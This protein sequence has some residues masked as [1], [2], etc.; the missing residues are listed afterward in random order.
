MVPAQQP[1]FT[2]GNRSFRYGDG[3]FETARLHNKTLLLA[4]YHFDR[5]F[6]GLQLLHMAFPFTAEQIN[7]LIVD[8]CN[9]ND[10]AASARVRMAAYRDAENSAS[11]LIEATM[12]EPD[13]MQWHKEGWHVTIH[14]DVRKA[15]DVLS[16]LKSANYLPYVMAALHAVQAGVDECLVLN[17]QGRVCDGSKT[18][19]F[20]MR[21]GVIVTPAL[22]EGPVAGVMRRALIRFLQEA[23]HPFVE[24]AV[25]IDDLLRADAVFLTNAIEGVRWV[26]QLDEKRYGPVS[27]EKLCD[28]FL[29]T[30]HR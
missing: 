10:C 6:S 30:V 29:S 18:N 24:T 11:L 23:G 1:L 8:L 12:L 27:L 7:G 16:N 28:S 3:L 9:R 4:A 13:R 5:L 25:T 19:V 14:P 22:S 21:D 15:S 17:A 26:R 2:G 20:L